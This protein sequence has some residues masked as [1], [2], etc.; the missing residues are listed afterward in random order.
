MTSQCPHCSSDN[1][2]GATYC[3]SCGKALPN[4]A[5][6]GPRIVEYSDVATTAAGSAA[7]VAELQKQI[8]KASGALLAVA[9]L[10]WVVGG[11]LAVVGT[12]LLADRGVDT[13]AMNVVYVT[14]FGVG[15][16]FF[17]LYLWSR[18]SPFPAAVVGLVVFVSLHL[19]EALADPASIYRGVI[20]KVIIIAI[21]IGAVKAG[22]RHRELKRQLGR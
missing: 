14:V 12:K 1:A 9:I 3:R 6:S 19:L 2:E 18:R 21:L 13:S 8:K 10:Q 20:V 22:V 15:A 5:S 4:P 17:G 11:L 7:Q 16:L